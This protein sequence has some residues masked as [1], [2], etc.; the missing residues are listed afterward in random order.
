MKR[1]VASSNHQVLCE[2]GGGPIVE[3]A[4]SLRA[5]PTENCF[6]AEFRYTSG[7]WF[8][9]SVTECLSYAYTSLFKPYNIFGDMLRKNGREIP[10]FCVTV[11]SYFEDCHFW[12]QRKA[13]PPIFFLFFSSSSSFS[14]NCQTTQSLLFEFAWHV[15]MPRPRGMRQVGALDFVSF[16]GADRW[17]DRRC[18][19]YIRIPS[20][21]S[22]T[23]SL[24]LL[25]SLFFS[26]GSQV[27]VCFSFHFSSSQ[28][29]K[30]WRTYIYFLNSS[31]KLSPFPRNQK[32]TKPSWY[33]LLAE[34]FELQELRSLFIIRTQSI[35]CN[36]FFFKKEN[37]FAFVW[38]CPVVG[39]CWSLS[40]TH[41]DNRSPSDG[42]MALFFGW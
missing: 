23:S 30:K 16:P 1:F 42:Y 21:H 35:V 26:V 19:S 25:Q 28:T 9:W 17:N 10:D 39:C 37:S 6:G 33:R 8:W 29:I 36:F 41:T 38:M 3:R 15:T 22:T 11:W 34:T 4:E 14:L 32:K 5:H 13:F 7:N 27:C 24:N 31:S 2:S 18:T 40:N 12:C 20:R